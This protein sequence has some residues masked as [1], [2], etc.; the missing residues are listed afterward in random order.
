MAKNARGKVW[1]TA[2]EARNLMTESEIQAMRA[3]AEKKKRPTLAEIGEWR[4]RAESL[5][6]ELAKTA[7]ELANARCANEKLDRALREETCGIKQPSESFVEQRIRERDVRKVVEQLRSCF[8]HR[9]IR[10]REALAA[11]N[12]LRALRAPEAFG[13]FGFADFDDVSNLLERIEGD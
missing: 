13:E 6:D 11:M 8:R 2:N 9:P 4:A 5:A 3:R 12:E 7:E 10:T 1:K